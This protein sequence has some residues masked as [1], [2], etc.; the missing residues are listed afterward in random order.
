[1]VKNLDIKGRKYEYLMALAVFM[2]VF[3]LTCFTPLLLEDYTLSF[4]LV[5]GEPIR[6]I[7]DLKQSLTEFRDHHN[8]RVLTHGIVQIIRLFPKALFNVLNGINAVLLMYLGLRFYKRESSNANA[9][10]MFFY[11]LLI[12]NFLPDFGHVFLWLDGSINYSWGLAVMSLYIWPYA[13]ACLEPDRKSGILKTVLFFPVSFAA[14]I[15]SE[16]GSIAII[17]M[18]IC[19][20][21]LMLLEKRRVPWHLLLGIVVAVFAFYLLM[22]APSEGGGRASE[23]TIS[24]IVNNFVYIVKYV[25]DRFFWLYCLYAVLLVLAWNKAD[26][27]KIYTGIVMVL[28]GLGSL[29]AFAFARYFTG[30]H[31]CFTVFFLVIACLMLMSE[32]Y[33]EKIMPAYK[34]LSGVLATLFLFNLVLGGI[35]ILATYKDHRERIAIMEQ[36]HAQ[37]LTEVTLPVLQSGSEYCAAARQLDLGLE[38]PDSWPNTDF[39][40]YYGFDRVIAEVPEGLKE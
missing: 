15:Y 31:C 21:L 18:A 39:A 25:K 14:G 24:A 29:T 34:V 33:G 35:D 9:L 38:D 32:L 7:G 27:R 37:G 19:F 23:K 20:V 26:R 2:L 28:G 5:T 12:W 10:M 22:S 40:R 16:N 8:G 4:N 3:I 36:A 6:S 13:A 11:A 30:R 1:M 17:F